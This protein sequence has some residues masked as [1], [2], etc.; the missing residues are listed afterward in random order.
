MQKQHLMPFLLFLFTIMIALGLPSP[1]L[2]DR[3]WGNGDFSFV[4]TKIVSNQLNVHKSMGPDQIHPK[5]LKS[6]DII[7]GPPQQF[8][9]GH[10]SLQRCLLD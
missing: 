9:K 8:I 5:V 6:D 7:A 3:N 10:R 2:E 1:L 4:V